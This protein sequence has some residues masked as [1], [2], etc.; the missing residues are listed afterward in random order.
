MEA[1]KDAED[2][3][4]AHLNEVE[5]GTLYPQA[6]SW[7]M[8]A[9]IPGKPQPV[10]RNSGSVLRRSSNENG[11]IRSRCSVRRVLNALK[12]IRVNRNSS[13]IAASSIK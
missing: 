3:W 9:N 10:G 5:Q 11:G 7:Y 8:G 6:N 2:K 1:K 4:V 12:A 13:P